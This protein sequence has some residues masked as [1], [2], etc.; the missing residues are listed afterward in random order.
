MKA[1]YKGKWVKVDTAYLFNNQ[2]NL[3]GVNKRIFD[4]EI[5]AIQNDARVGMG[6]CRWCGAM[7]KHGEEEKHFAEREEKEKDCAT[8]WYY[9]KEYISKPVVVMKE[10]NIENHGD[11]TTKIVSEV[12]KRDYVMECA[13]KKECGKCIHHECRARGIEWFTPENTFFLKYPNGIQSFTDV[14]KLKIYG[15]HVREGWENSSV[16]H[17]HK[18]IGSY[19]FS[20]RMGDDGCRLQWFELWNSRKSFRFL[21][22]NDELF[23]YDVS[24][25][26]EQTKRLDVPD[27]VWASVE[28]I[29]KC[30]EETISKT[31]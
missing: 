9:R 27:K 11:A 16:L 4:K 17:Y 8:C 12:V 28:R 5:K 26:W 30:I 29:C 22:V 21:I 31:A 1:F 6:K 20:A 23:V 7:V 15:F 2:Y 25:G 3:V 10:K 24:W 18:N 13:Y 19:E 14:D